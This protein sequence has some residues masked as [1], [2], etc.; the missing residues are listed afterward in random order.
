[1]LINIVLLVN[2]V[3]LV[4]VVLL[5]LVDIGLLVKTKNRVLLSY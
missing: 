1:M 2:S 5:G 3:I 4:D